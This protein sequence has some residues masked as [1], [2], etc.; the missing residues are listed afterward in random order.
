MLKQYNDL[1][2]VGQ[3]LMGFIA[4]NRGVSVASLYARQEY[5]VG[6]ND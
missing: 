2:D 3:Q 5:G 1:K 4:E 6:A